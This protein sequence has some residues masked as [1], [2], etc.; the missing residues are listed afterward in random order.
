MKYAS[1]RVFNY[2][3]QPFVDLFMEGDSTPYDLND[4]ENVTGWKVVKEVDDGEKRTGTKEWCAHAQIPK[5][6]QPIVSP[7]MLSWYEH[8]VWDRK[9]HVYT[10]QIEPFYLK[11]QVECHGRTMF[12]EKGPEKCAR[13]FE[14][15]L[16][17]KIPVFGPMFEKL[18]MELLKKNEDQDYQLSVKTAKK[19]FGK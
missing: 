7:K 19:H 5:A 18:V 4:L 17:V 1:E 16:T 3:L 11:K 15:H 9:A 13:R 12:V 8:S 10:F 6:L 14:I 2:P